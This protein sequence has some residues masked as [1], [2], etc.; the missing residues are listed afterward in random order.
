MCEIYAGKDHKKMVPWDG[1]NK[2][3]VY[4][5]EV[6]I[7]CIGRIQHLWIDINGYPWSCICPAYREE[8]IADKT[9]EDKKELKTFHNFDTDINNFSREVEEIKHFINNLFD[10]KLFIQGG[11]GTGKTHICK[12]LIYKLVQ[13][14]I[15]VEMFTA[16]ELS[17]IFRANITQDFEY[18]QKLNR[19]YQNDY[20]IID[21]LNRERVTDSGFFEE[22]FCQFLD[23]FRGKLII[24]SNNSIDKMKYGQRI[25]SRLYENKKQVVL[26]GKDYRRN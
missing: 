12:A 21:D 11:N 4:P 6:D 22:E 25:K 23:D 5:Q 20:I 15:K 10:K 18:L 17:Y 9:N 24:T 26:I 13:N 14:G 1:V 2:Y 19:L 16:T 8:I 3:S 7:L